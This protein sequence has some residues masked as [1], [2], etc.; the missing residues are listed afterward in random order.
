MRLC[1]VRKMGGGFGVGHFLHVFLSNDSVNR[2]KASVGDSGRQTDLDFYR[3]TTKW[4]TFRYIHDEV[5]SSIQQNS[6]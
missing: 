3:L 6:L 4:E 1:D 5:L 2:F